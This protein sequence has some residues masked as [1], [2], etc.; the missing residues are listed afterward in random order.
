MQQL[1]RSIQSCL[2]VKKGIFRIYPLRLIR[3]VGLIFLKKKKRKNKGKK[4]WRNKFNLYGNKILLS[5]LIKYLFFHSTIRQNMLISN[6]E[7][8]FKYLHI[9]VILS[10]RILENI[11]MAFREREMA[12]ERSCFRWIVSWFFFHFTRKKNR[13][14]GRLVRNRREENLSK[15]NE[16]ISFHPPPDETAASQNWDQLFCL[17]ATSE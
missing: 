7:E 17:G 8:L 12:K 1:V 9:R 2:P 4:E 14:R 13:F 6:T 10:L 5:I 11:L 3:K 16:Q 15:R